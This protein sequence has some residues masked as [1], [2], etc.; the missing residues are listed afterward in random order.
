MVVSSSS[1]ATDPGRL[2]VI[3]GCMFAGKT[4]RL[5]ACL[6]AAATAGRRVVA[7]K[8]ALDDR[9]DPRD[10]VTHDRRRLRATP[11]RDAAEIRQQVADADVVGIDE[12][13]FFGRRLVAAVA[14]LRGAG[15]LVY[16][17]GLEF[18]AWGR[19]FPPLPELQAIADE[20][21]RLRAPCSVCGAPAPYSQRMV[22]VTD[23]HMVG[24]PAEYEPRCERHF[25]PLTVPAPAYE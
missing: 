3:C 18:D 17:V 16:V 1:N 5:I 14:A 23:E 7:C 11:V 8:H 2:V 10:L 19:P 22:P 25:E 6:E 12:A 13:H 4:G 21:E 9:Y 24:G 20:V 15:R